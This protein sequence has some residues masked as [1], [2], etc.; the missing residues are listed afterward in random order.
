MTL[1][2]MDLDKDGFIGF[3]D[4]EATVVKEPLFLEA[5]GTCLP[6]DRLLDKFLKL[7]LDR[8]EGIKGLKN[9]YL[10]LT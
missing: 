10:G 5:F 3:N 2:K 4:F 7:I 8:K 1:R 6:T 9:Y